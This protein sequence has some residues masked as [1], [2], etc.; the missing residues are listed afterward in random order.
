M[1]TP[2]QDNRGLGGP[3]KGMEATRGSPVLTGYAQDTGGARDA[4]RMA[5]GGGCCGDR[6]GLERDWEWAPQKWIL[7]NYRLVSW[8]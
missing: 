8:T 2:Q 7:E 6:R 1:T 4:V 3:G 5:A